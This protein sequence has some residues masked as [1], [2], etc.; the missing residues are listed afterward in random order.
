MKYFTNIKSFSDLKKQFRALVIANH[1]DKGGSTEVMQEINKEFEQLYNIWK[2]R[3][4]MEQ[5]TT[6]YANDYEGASANE[7]SKNVYEEY[8]WTGSRRDRWYSRDE[9]K[10]IFAK[11]LKE[12]YKNCTFS[13]SLNGYKSIKVCLLKS[14]FNPF[15]GAVTYN[16]SLSR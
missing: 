1:P 13:I 15:K 4:D 3:K 10:K 2:D 14:D 11:W 7:Y 5:D 12:T 6:G 9:L 8:G 16:Y